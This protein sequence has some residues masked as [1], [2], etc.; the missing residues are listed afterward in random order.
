MA[1]SLSASHASNGPFTADG[2]VPARTSV[3]S[4]VRRELFYPGDVGVGHRHVALHRAGEEAH[5][6][7]HPQR[8]GRCGDEEAQRQAA[9]AQQQHRPAAEAIGERQ[10]IQPFSV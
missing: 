10:E 7:Q 9:D 4:A 8:R 1:P 5:R 6:H 3:R 2:C